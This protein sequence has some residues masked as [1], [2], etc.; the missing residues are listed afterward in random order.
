MTQKPHQTTR[1]SNC[2][3]SII[4]DFVASDP[5]P[6]WFWMIFIYFCCV[7]WEHSFKVWSCADERCHSE[8][9]QRVLWPNHFRGLDPPNHPTI[10]I[11]ILPSLKFV[12]VFWCFQGD[13]LYGC[14]NFG[15]SW[16]N[17]P[18]GPIGFI[19]N[20]QTLA[21]A[22]VR[23]M[24]KLVCTFLFLFTWCIYIYISHD[25]LFRCL[26]YIHFWSFLDVHFYMHTEMVVCL[27]VCH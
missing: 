26:L 14:M 8:W 27:T 19:L 7:W 4:L 2:Y 3:A 5:K 10:S 13:F 23:A 6:F 15:V 12:G 11:H 22:H 20:A 21:C 9:L 17:D 25:F 24:C 16:R 18:V 1:I